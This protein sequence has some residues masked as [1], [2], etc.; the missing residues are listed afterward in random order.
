[1]LL[2]LQCHQPK[3]NFSRSWS[4]RWE[5]LHHVVL[6]SYVSYDCTYTGC[7][8]QDIHPYPWRRGFSLPYWIRIYY[9][10]LRLY[11][12]TICCTMYRVGIWRRP[13]SDCNRLPAPS[14]YHGHHTISRPSIP[15]RVR[16]SNLYVFLKIKYI[17]F[18]SISL[19]A[20]CV[21]LF[22]I[23]FCIFCSNIVLLFDH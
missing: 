5:F 21:L 11:S 4:F 1:M 23:L 22:N 14:G 6:I 19:C 12:T 3:T 18:A 15:P 16:S 2:F 9:T 7:M 17:N 13:T 10:D 8:D 20:T